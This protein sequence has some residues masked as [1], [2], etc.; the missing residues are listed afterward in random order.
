MNLFKNLWIIIA[1][2]CSTLVASSLL[3]DCSGESEKV[4]S[5]DI[6]IDSIEVSLTKDKQVIDSIDYLYD[7]SVKYERDVN[8]KLLEENKKLKHQ[9]HSNHEANINNYRSADELKRIEFFESWTKP[10]DESRGD[11]GSNR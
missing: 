3:I 4:K 10:P 5:I 6:S 2:L 7:L 11:N 8:K 9:I 1:L